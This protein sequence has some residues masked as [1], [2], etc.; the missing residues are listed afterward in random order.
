MDRIVKY[1]MADITGKIIK[2]SYAVH[3]YFGGP[4]FL[5][6]VYAR[7]LAIELRNMGLQ[8]NTQVPVKVYFK[9]QLVGDFK[10]DLLVENSVIVE[11]KA[12]QMAQ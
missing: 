8:V 2:A 12:V 4:G 3:N 10:A 5:E 6:S 9:G 11:L 1:P 7:S